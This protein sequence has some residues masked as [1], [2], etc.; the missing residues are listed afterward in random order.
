MKFKERFV[1]IKFC[2]TDGTGYRRVTFHKFRN[3]GEVR[4][5]ALEQSWSIE[6]DYEW[7]R[8]T[9]NE[10]THGGMN[11]PIDI[12]SMAFLRGVGTLLV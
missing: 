4:T 7:R 6:G 8:C 2:V 10:Y 5:W 11:S 12:G 9:H 3:M 1:Y